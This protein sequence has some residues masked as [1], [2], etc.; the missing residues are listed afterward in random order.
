[1][2][3]QIPETAILPFE[4]L[5]IPKL[6]VLQYGSVIE[7]L[8]T[9]FETMNEYGRNTDKLIGIDAIKLFLYSCLRD[10][11]AL[12]DTIEIN[13]WSVQ[14]GHVRALAEFAMPDKPMQEYG[15]LI[16]SRIGFRKTRR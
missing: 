14:G 5:G 6:G 13:V 3:I 8:D 11:G 2:N 15:G 12:K 16:R 10:M 1:M 7:A 9:A 4:P